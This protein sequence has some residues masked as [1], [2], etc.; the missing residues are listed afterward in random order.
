MNQMSKLRVANHA[1]TAPALM[2]RSQAA[3][4]LPGFSNAHRP[5]PI[6]STVTSTKTRAS[7]GCSE[8]MSTAA[9]WIAPAPNE[10]SAA[11]ARPGNRSCR[12]SDE[13]DGSG[14]SSIGADGSMGEV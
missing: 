14:A 1:S 5:Q 7:V 13:V 2:A 10:Q 12:A 11:T 8:W 3:A 4:A 9:P 6:S